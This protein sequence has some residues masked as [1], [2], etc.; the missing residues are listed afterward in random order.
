[1]LRWAE[2]KPMLPEDAVVDNNLRSMNIV[3]ADAFTLDM[4]SAW[5]FAPQ[6]LHRPTRTAEESAWEDGQPSEPA[7]PVEPQRDFQQRFHSL[8][9]AQRYYTARGNWFIVVPE[10]VKKALQVVRE[11]QDAPLSERLAF[12]ANP[13]AVL[14]ESFTNTCLRRS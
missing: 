3:R 11:H 5:D 7:L 4:G 2:M 8:S 10:N 14:R 1:M 13:A 6:L 9:S 12:I